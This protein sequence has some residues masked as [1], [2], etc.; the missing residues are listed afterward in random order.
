M[1]LTIVDY[2]N[3]VLRQKG[4]PIGEITPELRAFADEMIA[5]MEKARGI[6]LAAQQVGRPIQLCVVDARPM[7]K[8]HP[9]WLTVDGKPE[10]VAAWM[11]MILVNPVVSLH[12]E[13]DLFS[14]G[15][16]S[17]PDLHGTV[18]RATRI[19]VKTRLIDGRVVEFEAGGM[20]ARVIQHEVDHLQGM[21]FIDRMNSASRAALAGKLKR[22]QRDFAEA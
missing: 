17:F 21:L 13:R 1:P 19:N 9:N 11:P 12:P 3:P 7:L 22:M 6:G 10:D 2:P 5:A 8:E 18:A 4:E 15:C 16:L 20:L 14:E